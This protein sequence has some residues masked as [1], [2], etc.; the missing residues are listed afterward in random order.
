MAVPIPNISAG[1][2]G[3]S[4]AKAGDVSA[5][6]TFDFTSNNAFSV[7]GS[8][9]QTQTANASADEGLPVNNNLPLYIGIGVAVVA[10]L[11]IGF[12]LIKRK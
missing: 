2:G 9:K 3:P 10:L 5:G 12:V 7:G 11:G 6:M 8:G 1:G 4:A